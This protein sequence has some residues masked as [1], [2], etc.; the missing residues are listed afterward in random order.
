M[1]VCPY[2][3]GPLFQEVGK[4]SGDVG[5]ARDKGS[6]VSKYSQ[7][8]LYLFQCSEFLWPVFQAFDFDRV[9]VDSF[10]TDDDP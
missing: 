8:R 10:S 1:C 7:C 5:K 2:E 9:D 6:L 4:W 3:V